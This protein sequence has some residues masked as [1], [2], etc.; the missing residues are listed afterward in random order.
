MYEYEMQKAADT[1][2]QKMFQVKKGES[3]VITCDSLSCM[4]VVNAVASSAHAAGAHPMIIKFPAPDGVG[5][6][7]DPKLPM[8]PLTAAV[9]NCDV[10]IEFNQKWLLYSTPYQKAISV[11]KKLRY[12]CLVEFTEDVMIRT[13]SDIDVEKL[14]AFMN[15]VGDLNRAAKHIRMTTPSGT[16][17]TFE[18]DDR[19][20]V[21]VDTGDASASGVYMMLGQLNVVPKFG[22]VNGTIV[23]DGTVTPPFGRSPDQPIKLTV[24]D[25]VIVDIHGGSDA[26]AYE[27]WLKGFND[28][29]MLKMAHVAYGFNPGAKLSGNVVEDERVW[30]VTEWGIGYVSPTIGGPEGQAAVSHTDGI[31]L[32]TSVWLDGVQIMDEGKMTDPNLEAMYPHD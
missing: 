14:S 4:T 5:Q 19:H 26:A 13:M 27:K 29:G 23:F 18:T 12:M 32:N 31:C 16:D 8:E 15:T 1:L 11:N 22:S 30:G 21:S 9:S 10:W 20:V 28:P 24:K 25:S 6:A 17:V 7:A 3:V 2:I